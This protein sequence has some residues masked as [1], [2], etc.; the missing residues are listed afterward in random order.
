MPCEMCKQHTYKISA[1]LE[2]YFEV[3]DFNALCVS[4]HMAVHSR[5]SS[6]GGWLKYLIKLRE[7]FKPA[8][9][10]SVTNYFGSRCNKEFF[11]VNAEDTKYYINN[12]EPLEGLWYENLGLIKTDLR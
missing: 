10:R 6:I 4:C 2:N 8:R 7:G 12:F 9:Y 1:H 11:G 5:F 3:R